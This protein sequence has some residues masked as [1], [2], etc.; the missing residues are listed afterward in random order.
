M[1]QDYYDILGV[2][3]GAS[4]EELKKA[5]RKQAMKF[6]PDKNQGN[7]EAEAKFKELNEAYE[8]LKDDQK[9]AA[10]DRFGHAAFQ[11]GGGGGFQGGFQG[12]GQGFGSFSDIF[13]AMFRGASGNGF[14]DQGQGAHANNQ[15]SDIR[16]NMDISLEEAFKGTSSRLKFNTFGTCDPC[17]GS[18]GEKGS[19]PAT[20][21]TCKGRGT[22]RFQQSLFIVERPCTSCGGSGQTIANPCRSCQGQGRAKK[23][24][25]I[26]VK[27]PAGVDIP[28]K[29]LYHQP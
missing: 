29:Q 14:G 5:Y 17:G 24:K 20:C 12:D 18:G 15:G 2:S 27:I 1:A 6:H 10:Y 26:E 23:E 21:T 9:R 13:E 16:Y 25:N 22:M 8:V 4:E 7:K 19:K 3:K 28:R 11:Q